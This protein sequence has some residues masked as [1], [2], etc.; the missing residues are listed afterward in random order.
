MA[1]SARLA[2]KIVENWKPLST[3][4]GDCHVLLKDLRS[5]G[6]FCS[7]VNEFLEVPKNMTKSQKEF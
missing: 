2:K 6:F 1:A 5:I 4:S 3:G 7:K